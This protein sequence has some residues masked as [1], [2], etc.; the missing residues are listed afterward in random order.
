MSGHYSQRD[1]CGIQRCAFEARPLRRL[2][3][4]TDLASTAVPPMKSRSRGV[5][6]IAGCLS[7]TGSQATASS[8]LVAYLF[9][10]GAAVASAL[11]IRRRAAP[12]SEQMLAAATVIGLFGWLAVSQFAVLSAAE[13]S[14]LVWATFGAL[15]R[16]HSSSVT[17]SP[18]LRRVSVAEVRFEGRLAARFVAMSHWARC[19]LFLS[20]HRT[21]LRIFHALPTRVACTSR[22]LR[23]VT[24]MSS[25]ASSFAR[26]ASGRYP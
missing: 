6:R 1:G 20:G 11:A 17:F 4:S 26:I 18:T 15:A 7:A 13:S 5:C 24:P 22:R 23:K 8:G 16:A 25:I 12:R 2:I 21:N 3:K 9:V 14:L 10:F 19:D